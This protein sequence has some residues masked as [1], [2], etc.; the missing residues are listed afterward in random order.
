MTSSITAEPY[1][2]KQASMVCLGH[3]LE[4][5]S[6]GGIA[7]YRSLYVFLLH[8]VLGFDLIFRSPGCKRALV[9][10]PGIKRR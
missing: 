2:V 3:V 4:G 8:Y 5:M 9:T 10:K 7:V 6:V 1:E